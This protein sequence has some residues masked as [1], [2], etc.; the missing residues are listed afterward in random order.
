VTGSRPAGAALSA[1]TCLALAALNR[2]V[3]LLQG[4]VRGLVETTAGDRLAKIGA[5]ALDHRYFLGRD[6][7][8]IVGL[9]GVGCSWSR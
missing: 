8:R 3:T 4:R 6:A 1:G 2:L 9:S 5:P 7:R